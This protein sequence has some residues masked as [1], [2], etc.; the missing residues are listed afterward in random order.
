MTAAR[1]FFVICITS[2]ISLYSSGN[3]ITQSLNPISHTNSDQVLLPLLATTMAVN[4]FSTHQEADVLGDDAP[5]NPGCHWNL[6]I[7][8]T[9]LSTAQVP[10]GPLGLPD[11]GIERIP[12]L[13]HGAAMKTPA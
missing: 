3:Q 11:K 5:P 9:A 10:S 2:A 1:H 8:A 4:E 6:V 13:V 7:V 12:P